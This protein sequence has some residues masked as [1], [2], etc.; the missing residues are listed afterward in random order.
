MQETMCCSYC[1]NTLAYSEISP[2]PMNCIHILCKSC[3]ISLKACQ[4]L[5]SCPIDKI[6]FGQ[7]ICISYIV[8]QKR[9]CLAHQKDIKYLCKKH[10]L[11]CCKNCLRHS[12]CDKII[13]TSNE[14]EKIASQILNDS[15]KCTSKKQKLIEKCNSVI[16]QKQ[17]FNESYKLFLGLKQKSVN[18]LNRKKGQNILE[19]KKTI[20]V[21]DIKSEMLNDI[22]DMQS[23]SEHEKLQLETQNKKKNIEMQIEKTASK[24]KTIE[25]QIQNLDKINKNLKFNFKSVKNELRTL[26]FK[27]S[28]TIFNFFSA[29]LINKNQT[30][31]F[32]GYLKFTQD[33][34]FKAT[35][36]GIGL[37]SIPEKPL[38]VREIMVAYE[39]HE[40][41]IENQIL[42]YE[43]GRLTTLLQLKESNIYH[44]KYKTL[45]INCC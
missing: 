41:K 27:Q 24:I 36:L 5:Y 34:Y 6:R 38:F 37:P 21:V 19:M 16:S 22:S 12:E 2:I 23:L 43:E 44:S 33:F 31:T 32:A 39:S 10:L 30:E 29:S 11:L 26:P 42:N 17:T 15:I 20:S 35:G 7:S 28:L 14:I 1:L 45:Y 40:Y 13:G 18:F 4:N 3:V 25:K 8:H 9:F